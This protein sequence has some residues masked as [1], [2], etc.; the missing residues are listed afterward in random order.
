MSTCKSSQSKERV[1]ERE[2]NNRGVAERLFSEKMLYESVY[3][4]DCVDER[5]REPHSFMSYFN[6]QCLIIYKCLPTG[7]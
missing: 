5:R 3:C 2:D 4:Y 6:A 1:Q 7:N